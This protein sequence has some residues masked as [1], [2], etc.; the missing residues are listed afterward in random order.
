MSQAGITSVTGSSPTIPTSFVTNSGTAVPAANVLN[1][2]GAGDTTTSG[3]GNTITITTPSGGIMW[4][5]ITTS[6]T[7]AAGN[8]YVCNGSGTV[9]LTLPAVAPVGTTIAAVNLNNA[10]GTQFAVPTGGNIRIGNTATTTT[11]GTLTSTEVGDTITLLCMVA[12]TSWI[13]IADNGNWTF[14]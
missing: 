3:S 5:T 4:S 9:V 1:V 6:Q 14:T 10:T 11:T 8:G 2:F 12:N 7:A 13:A